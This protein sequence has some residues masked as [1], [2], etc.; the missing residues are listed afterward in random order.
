MYPLWMHH[1]DAPPLDA[2]HSGCT[3]L[4]VPPPVDTL[5]PSEC[6]PSGCT[7]LDASPMCTTWMHHSPVDASPSSGCTPSP[8][9]RWST[10]GQ[11]ASRWNAYLLIDLT[12]CCFTNFE[13]CSFY[14]PES[15]EGNNFTHVCLSTGQASQQAS[16]V[17]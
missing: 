7:P 10:G 12:T 17:T 11:Y 8:E 16:L 2:F 4:D 9:D 6:T 15:G 13:H 3:S 5:L 1:P 14:R